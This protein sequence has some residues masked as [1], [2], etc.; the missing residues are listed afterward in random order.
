MVPGGTM[1]IKLSF[2]LMCQDEETM[3]GQHIRFLLKLAKSI[4]YPVEFVIA[5]GG[6]K[7]NTLKITNELKDDRFKIF[8]NPWPGAPEQRNFIMS[9]SEGE[10]T[11]LIDTDVTISDSIYGKINELLRAGSEVAAYSFPRIH[12]VQDTSHMYN[13]PLSPTIFLFRN[14]PGIHFRGPGMETWYFKDEPIQQHPSHFN[15]PWQKYI[16]EIIMIHF[17][18]LKSFEEKVRKCIRYSFVERNKWYGRTEGQIREILK[19]DTFNLDPTSS[20]GSNRK[21]VCPISERFPNLQFY[22]E[23]D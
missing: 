23:F 10:W 19:R 1:K 2:H 18:D 22:T 13:V 21:I 11:F 3:I 6:S 9:K 20:I 14:I 8:N 17:A 5:D 7:D 12:L 16:P 15:F 4:D